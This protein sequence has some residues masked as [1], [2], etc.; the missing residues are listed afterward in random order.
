MY[1][2]QIPNPEK[3]LADPEPKVF[4]AALSFKEKYERTWLIDAIK[5]WLLHI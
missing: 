5:N 4:F 2:G 1:F 3:T